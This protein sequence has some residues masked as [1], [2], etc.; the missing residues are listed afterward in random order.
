MSKRNLL[1]EIGLEEMPARFINGAINQFADKIGAWFATKKIDYNELKM[2]STPRRLAVLVTDVAESQED[3]HEEAKGPAKKIA[4][5]ED[6]SWSKAAQGF[7]RGQGM[8]VEDIYFKEI[9]GVEYAHVKKFIEG[10]DTA[11]L[12]PEMK[13]II[14]GLTF[15]KNMRWANEELR[16]VRPIKWLM[17]IFGNDVI[18][19]SI[20]GVETSNQTRGHRFLGTEFELGSP[21]NY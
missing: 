21:D 12:L 1:L 8:S 15:P 13:S 20:T 11:N 17:A 19:F 10:Q 9:N 14:T 5:A 16:Y 6:G 2:F 4:L 3:S 18:P 7:T